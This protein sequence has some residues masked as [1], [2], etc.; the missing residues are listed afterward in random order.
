MPDE[1]RYCPGKFA[2]LLKIQGNFSHLR[3]NPAHL[4]G[5][6]PP[7]YHLSIDELI[8]KVVSEPRYASAEAYWVTIKARRSTTQPTSPLQSPHQRHVTFHLRDTMPT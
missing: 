7:V 2:P 8:T 5:H 1:K 4:V 6:V 3:A